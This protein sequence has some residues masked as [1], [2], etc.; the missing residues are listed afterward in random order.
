MYY[1]IMLK[2]IT[3]LD[4]HKVRTKNL[5]DALM[6]Q[7]YENELAMRQAVEADISGLRRVLD[8]LTLARSD[9]E[10]QMNHEEVGL[11]KTSNRGYGVIQHY[12]TM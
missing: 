8:E 12:S 4:K 2:S 9:L 7:R 10:M 1:T 6:L 3:N 5:V 11:L